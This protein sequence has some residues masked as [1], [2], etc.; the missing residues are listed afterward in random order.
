MSELTFVFSSMNGGKS[1]KLLQK[2][3]SLEEAGY[4]VMLMKPS[5][6]TRS[7]NKI[8]SRLGIEREA[9]SISHFKEILKHIDEAAKTPDYLLI[10]EAQFLSIPQIEVL[11][12]DI[13]DDMKINVV[14]YGLK[15]SWQ[16]TLF[17]GSKRL[18]ELAD[19]IEQ[20]DN[21]CKYNKG[22]KAFFHTKS[23]SGESAIEVGDMDVYESVSRAKWY[24]GK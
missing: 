21:L 24:L 16:G 6:D 19:N 11:A 1:T 12:H 18:I 15:L 2:A 23:T 20:M 8:T 5:I 7:S 13:V 22:S 17:E 14:C 3:H 4:N 9:H 10:D